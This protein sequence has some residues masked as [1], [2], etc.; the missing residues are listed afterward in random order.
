MEKPTKRKFFLPTWLKFLF[1]IVFILVLVTAF[2]F[3]SLSAIDPKSQKK[4]KFLIEKGQSVASIVHNL[5]QAGLIR[6]EKVTYYFA[7]ILK[8]PFKA[9]SYELS[10]N[11]SVQEIFAELKTGKQ[12]TIRVT[13]PE[14]FTVS[15]V[16]VILEKANIVSASEFLA[17]AKTGEPLKS[18]GIT[19]STCE[20]FLF[21]ETYFLPEHESAENILK[22]LLE[23]FFKKVKNIQDFPTETSKILDAVKL[24]SIVEREYRLKEEAPIIAGVFFNRIAVNMP[25]QSCTS[26]EYIITEIQKKEH[27][28]RIFWDDLKIDNPYNTY[29]YQGLPPTP[30]CSPGLIALKAVA[31]PKTHDY[32]YFRLIDEKTGKHSFSRTFLEHST[33]GSGIKLKG[34]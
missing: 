34:F 7:R 3:Y 14:G 21:P 12:K 15:K 31:E 10:K 30:I 11:M 20:G 27:P 25:L 22:V 5:K 26:I 4:D 17:L 2:C 18:Y 9:G 1:F 16:A 6:S 32:L 33:K 24:A 13:I 28:K 29:M 19:A 8:T 23:T